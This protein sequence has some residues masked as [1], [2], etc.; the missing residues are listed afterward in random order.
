MG[1]LSRRF[2]WMGASAVVTFGL[3]LLAAFIAFK[4][5][6]S[7]VTKLAFTLESDAPV[8]QADPS[9]RGRMVV[10]FEGTT[11][12]QVRVLT[13]RIRN[14]GNTPIKPADFAE[15]IT[16]TLEEG[17]FLSY[18]VLDASP[19]EVDV[20]LA[21]LARDS[22]QLPKIL[23]NP[24]DQIRVAVITTSQKEGALTVS[25]RVSG[26]KQVRLESPRPE[27]GPSPVINAMQIVAAVASALIFLT[28]VPML[29]M[30]LRRYL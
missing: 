21:S 19:E 6:E 30:R 11:V 3:S 17:Q 22:V 16:F 25:A 4:G 13:V 8:I 2:V 15:P 29:L 14:A 23:L 9:V 20:G 27:A 18:D 28:G 1:P 24:G 12:P 10:T 5:F 26:V 7:E